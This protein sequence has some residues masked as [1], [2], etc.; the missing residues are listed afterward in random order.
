M[1]TVGLFRL[2]SPAIVYIVLSVSF[3]LL[4]MYQNRYYPN[5]YCVGDNCELT[6]WTGIYLIK[7]VFIVFWAW[8]LNILCANSFGFIA[9]ILVLI[10]PAIYIFLLWS[11]VYAPIQP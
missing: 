10:P 7:I 1:K 9:W 3:L 5:V 2:C 4:V 6:N 11:F 8:I